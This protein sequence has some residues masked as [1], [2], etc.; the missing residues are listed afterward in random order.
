MFTNEQLMSDEEILPM[1]SSL[2]RGVRAICEL[3]EHPTIDTE[4]DPPM[5]GNADVS[6]I[7]RISPTSFHI[8]LFSITADDSVPDF[9][10]VDEEIRIALVD[11]ESSILLSDIVSVL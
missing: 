6:T 4:T 10:N 2:F 11:G 8:Q 3:N 1:S 5:S 7:P 9:S